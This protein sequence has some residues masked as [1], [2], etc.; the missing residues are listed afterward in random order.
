MF[1]N[2]Q[3]TPQ[4]RLVFIQGVAKTL[5]ALRLLS[6]PQ[7]AHLGWWGKLWNHAG[8]GLDPSLS[9]VIFVALGNLPNV[10]ELV[11][12]SKKKKKKEK[13]NERKHQS[14]TK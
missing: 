6:P 1:W 2:S 9:L 5:R 7:C 12:L 13:R 10:S 4:Q 8:L 11:F 14:K 3:G